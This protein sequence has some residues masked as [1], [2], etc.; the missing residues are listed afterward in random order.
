MN[1]EL[2]KIS[3]ESDLATGHCEQGGGLDGAVCTENLNSDVV[4]VKSTKSRV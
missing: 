3:Y 2:A 1:R 4:M